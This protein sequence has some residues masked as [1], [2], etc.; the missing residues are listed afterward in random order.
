MTFADG[1]LSGTEVNHRLLA[2]VSKPIPTKNRSR[3]RTPAPRPGAAEE[4][5]LSPRR[6]P[7]KRDSV[8]VMDDSKVKKQ[9]KI[10]EEFYDTEKSYVR[11]LDLIYSVCPSSY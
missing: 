7:R 9:R 4:A 5:Q 1:R 10:I 6:A 2:A 3:S 11:G 8:R